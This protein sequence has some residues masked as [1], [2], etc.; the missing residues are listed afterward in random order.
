MFEGMKQK[1]AQLWRAIKELCK[2]A[3]VRDD[4]IQSLKGPRGTTPDR[5]PRRK[6]QCFI[7]GDEG[8]WADRCP[9]RRSVQGVATGKVRD[10]PAGS[11]VQGKVHCYAC[12]GLGHYARQCVAA[13]K[14]SVEK[15]AM[16]ILRSPAS[17]EGLAKSS[18]L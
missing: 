11:V 15:E 16:P 3:G 2:R 18:L 4:D 10:G 13:A 6:G 1:I 7:C 14:A 17:R 5:I 8:H 12:G 9:T